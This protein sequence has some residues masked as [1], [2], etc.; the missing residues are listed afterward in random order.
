MITT[1]GDQIPITEMD[2]NVVAMYVQ[3]VKLKF[4]QVFIPF[5][6]LFKTSKVETVVLEDDYPAVGLL[7]YISEFGI[8]TL[9]L[10]SYSSNYM[11]RCILAF[12]WLWSNLQQ[13]EL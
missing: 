10:G 3:E 4:G 8:Q 11:K 6:N 5:L 1:A 13:C 12:S 9:V 2:E 7:R